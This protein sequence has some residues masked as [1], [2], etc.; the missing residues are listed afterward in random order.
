[1]M[2]C[3]VGRQRGVGTNWSMLDLQIDMFWRFW[4]KEEKLRNL[5][6][7]FG[8]LFLLGTCV[9]LLF[10]PFLPVFVSITCDIP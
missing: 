7:L 6:R 9:F 3:S 10:L 2:M 8:F 4:L 1:M 5:W